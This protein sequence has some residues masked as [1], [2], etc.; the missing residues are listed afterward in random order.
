[1]TIKSFISG[2][3]VG[4]DTMFGMLAKKKGIP[5]FNM[6]FNLHNCSSVGKRVV[7]SQEQLDSRKEDMEII[8]KVLHKKVGKNSYINN[9]M[10]RNTFQIKSAKGNLTDLVIAVGEVEV[11][12]HN[13]IGGTGYAI[14]Y[15][16]YCGVPVVLLNKN[17]LKFYFY[18]KAVKKFVLMK[19]GDLQNILPEKEQLV[20]TGV[21]SRE[22][23][24]DLVKP[25][26]ERLIS[27]I[28]GKTIIPA[29][30]EVYD[31]PDEEVPVPMVQGTLY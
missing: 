4:S 3:A 19:K 12:Y 9:L 16:Q 8:R 23:K 15:A 22:I 27:A 25:R 31:L 30:T 6:S 17:D 13:V 10:L 20:I 14:C 24:E 29:P 11:N 28:Q 5:C 21:G 2:G 1:M 18:D 26:I 7:L